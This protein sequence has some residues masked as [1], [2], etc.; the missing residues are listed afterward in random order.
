MDYIITLSCP[1]KPGLVL[2]V[3]SWLV[4]NTCNILDSDQFRDGS[5]NTFF[6][7]IHFEGEAKFKALEHSFEPIATG[8]Q[9]NWQIWPC[10]QKPKVLVMVSKQDHCLTDLLFR[11]KNGELPIEIAL[12]A[13]NHLNA[14]PIAAAEN[15]DF[16]HL[17]IAPDSKTA[18]ET[19]L[20]E[21]IERRN[22]NVVVL[23]RYMQI[24]SPEFCQAMTGKIINIHHSFLPGFKGARPYHQAFEHGVKLIGATAHYVTAELDEGP[25]IEQGIERVGH[26]S[27]V[28]DLVNVGRDIERIVLAKAVKYHAEHRVLLNDHRTVVFH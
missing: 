22:I 25:I 3:S 8:S 28:A 26:R 4:A 2:A 19:L 11:E 17:P 7:R 21:E 6:M 16:R 10:A 5:N 1:D 13:S 23:A 14:E 24:L 20:L 27:T 9:M 15:I 12:I 18:Q